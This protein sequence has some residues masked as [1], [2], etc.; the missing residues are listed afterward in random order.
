MAPPSALIPI[1]RAFSRCSASIPRQSSAF[2]STSSTDRAHVFYRQ[3]QIF[4][5]LYPHLP[6]DTST[7]S[8]NCPSHPAKNKPRP[9]LST[10]YKFQH[11]LARRPPYVSSILHQAFTLVLTPVEGYANED[12]VA[13]RIRKREQFNLL[14]FD[15]L[16]EKGVRESISGEMAEEATKHVLVHLTRLLG[17]MMLQQSTLCLTSIFKSRSTICKEGLH[18]R[19]SATT[20]ALP[21][22][23]H[24]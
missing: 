15:M 20:L 24:K 9:H 18:A 22:L 12:I 16:P 2:A 19:L 3:A 4:H 14:L 13:L 1:F 8:T 7:S 6:S 11:G 5:G 23:T 17:L 10:G 21:T